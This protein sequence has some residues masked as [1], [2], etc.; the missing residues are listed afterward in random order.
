MAVIEGRTW[1]E[2]MPEPA[3]RRHL[4][5]EH[6]GRVV[7][8]VGD[9]PE[10]FP[11]NYAMDGDDVVFRTDPG[12]KLHAVDEQA[13]VAFEIDEL[14]LEHRTGWSV[15]VVGK[16]RWVSKPEDLRRLRD[17]AIEPWAHG[18]KASWVRIIPTKVTGRRIHPAPSSTTAVH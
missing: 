2:V 14:D 18:D 17:V 12:T 1:L 15:L 16:A 3:C 8:S 11:V 4:H 6:V 9:H 7:V 13:K 5:Q 10:A